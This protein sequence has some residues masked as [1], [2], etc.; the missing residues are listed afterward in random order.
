MIWLRR[1]TELGLLIDALESYEGATHHT[2][3]ATA[4]DV[5]GQSEP[6]SV[7]PSLSAEDRAAFL[8]L[9]HEVEEKV[10]IPFTHE[11]LWFVH[12]VSDWY[13]TEVRPGCWITRGMVQSVMFGVAELDCPPY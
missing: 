9:L 10:G 2:A 8:P 13:G 5:W 4:R 12:G 3:Y 6:L 7:H 1:Y 11:E